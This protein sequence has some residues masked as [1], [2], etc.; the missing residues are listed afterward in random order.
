MNKLFSILGLAILPLATFAQEE[1]SAFSQLLTG[2]NK[3][4]IVVIVLLIIF[5]G[6]IFFLTLLDRKIKR[7]EEKIN[8]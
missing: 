2:S 6:I 3:M 5:F 7:L 4:L 1:A 8:Q